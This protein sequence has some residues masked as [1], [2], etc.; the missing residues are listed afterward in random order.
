ML[1]VLFLLGRFL[2]TWLILRHEKAT[3][4]LYSKDSNAHLWSSVLH[5]EFS[6]TCT[7]LLCICFVWSLLLV[8]IPPP[9]F[10]Y[11]LVVTVEW[12]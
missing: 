9:P 4:T 1:T 2:Q 5:A 10:C 8:Y 12:R 7:P 3:L 6:A 11:S